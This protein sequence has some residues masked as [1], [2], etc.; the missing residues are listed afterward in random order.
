MGRYRVL[1]TT[2]ILALSAG[3]SEA[4]AQQGGHLAVGTRAS[5]TAP[6]VRTFM[7]I[8]RGDSASVAR[9][10]AVVINSAEEWGRIVPL[11]SDRTDAAIRTPPVDFAQQT[12]VAIFQG[13][14][15]SGGRGIE[16]DGITEHPTHI[17]FTTSEFVTRPDCE[18][19]SKASPYEIVVIPKTD[20]RV[21][22]DTFVEFV[23]CE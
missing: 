5:V 3:F 18:Q 2:T 7:T 19:R 20:K 17:V 23:A 11:L 8:A 4:R 16:I 15:G 22:L 10:T 21:E 9:L 14:R 6:P 1:V 13:H 12:V